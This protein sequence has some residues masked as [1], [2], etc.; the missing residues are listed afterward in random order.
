MYT[1]KRTVPHLRN[2]KERR[3]AILIF[4][5]SIYTGLFLALFLLMYFSFNLIYPYKPITIKGPAKVENKDKTIA[6]GDF[7]RVS[8]DYEKFT[9]KPA[10]AA[11]Q[12]IGDLAYELPM[13]ITN[14]PKGKFVIPHVEKI[15]ES[16]PPGKYRG[17][18]T[19][20]YDYPPFRHVHYVVETE[21][22]TVVKNSNINHITTEQA[23]GIIDLLEE[24]KGKNE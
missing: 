9:D 24:L 12:F 8:I 20:T 23:Q 3:K 18:I 16:I 7:I 11:R 10:L 21:E 4:H 5:Y 2:F 13:R 14:L 1:E 17:I 15:P 19:L 22:F 6:A